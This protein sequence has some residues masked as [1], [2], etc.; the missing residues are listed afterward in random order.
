MA[1][2]FLFTPVLAED[3]VSDELKQQE[4]KLQE[5]QSK[6]QELLNEINR[7]RNEKTSLANQ[8]AYLESQIGL[9]E[10]QIQI[11]SEEI[12]KQEEEVEALT[13]NIEDLS[14]K[15]ERVKEYIDSLEVVL[16]ARVRSSYKKSQIGGGLSILFQ[17]K[18]DLQDLVYRYQY[19]KTVQD[20]DSRLLQQMKETQAEYD[21]QISDLETQKNEVE[22]L[23]ESLKIAIDQLQ[24]ENENLLQQRYSKDYLLRI[25]QNDEAR[26]QAILSQTIAEQ[27]ALQNAV[28][29]LYA[30]LANG[31][32]LEVKRGD[33]IGQQGS[34][35]I[36]TGEHLHFGLYAYTETDSINLC[37]SH[38]DPAPKLNSGE[39]AIPI[40]SPR[41]TSIPS[42]DE[43][44]ASDDYF[45]DSLGISQVYGKTNFALSTSIYG[46]ICPN[47]PYHK[48]ID[49]IGPIG[50]PV[51]AADDGVKYTIRDNNGGANGVFIFHANGLMTIYWHLR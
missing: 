37:Y 26:Y 14:G 34:S 2:T 31:E 32:G 10:L 22:T 12:Q 3:T 44:N 16:E 24:V 45:A 35:G 38:I 46:S 6:Q 27:V 29:N 13:L 4:A 36:G 49:M 51:Y 7:L 11:Q 28:N 18:D 43:Y 19:L 41:F 48:G 8:V 17:G 30:L 50:G 39:L 40:S 23:K 5:N 1:L 47:F 25:T 42:L 33:I 9:T 20:Q 15:I 21:T